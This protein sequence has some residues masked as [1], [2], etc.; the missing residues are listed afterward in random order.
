MDAPL[1]STT[2]ALGL[3]AAS[4]LNTTLPLVLAGLLARSGH[5]PLAPPYDALSSTPVLVLLTL[6]A[7]GELVGDK[8]PGLDSVLQALQWP[9]AGAAGAVLCASQVA[10]SAPLPAPA[11]SGPLLTITGVAPGLALVVGGLAAL[12]VYS[13]RTL[14]RPVVT[15]TTL[16]LGNSVVSAGEDLYALLLAASAVLLPVLGLVLLLLLGGVVVSIMLAA[17]RLRRGLGRLGG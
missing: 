14:V 8:T 10:D 16:G 7:A 1:L 9:A 4:G 13:A 5:L 15:V 2:T 6:L 12:A 17:R 11:L 3:A